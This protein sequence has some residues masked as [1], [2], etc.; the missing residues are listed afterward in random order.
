MPLDIL[1]EVSI[2]KK[3]FEKVVLDC[4]IC[5]QIFGHLRPYDILRLARTTKALRGILMRRSAIS[6]WKDARSNVEGLPDCPR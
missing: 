1:Y 3:T 2:D 5:Q 6:V 4:P